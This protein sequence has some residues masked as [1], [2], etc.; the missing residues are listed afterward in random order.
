MHPCSFA[1]SQFTVIPFETSVTKAKDVAIIAWSRL[2]IPGGTGELEND[3]VVGHIGQNHHDYPEL[4]ND[5][6]ATN[7]ADFETAI[8]LRTGPM[9][10]AEK[11]VGTSAD[12]YTYTG[13]QLNQC[14][15]ATWIASGW[16]PAHD[17]TW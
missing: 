7:L 14:D 16:G 10:V 9:K 13:S 12:L 2:N 15:I 4:Q 11:L 1:P 3:S 6:D 17:R 5:V 8:R